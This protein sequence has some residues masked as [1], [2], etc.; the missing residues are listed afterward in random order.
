[1]S[2]EDEN[3]T[4]NDCLWA[5]L[6]YWKEWRVDFPMQNFDCPDIIYGQVG[7][8]I[9]PALQQK[10]TTCPVLRVSRLN[11]SRRCQAPGYLW[12]LFKKSLVTVTWGLCSVILRSRQSRSE[13]LSLWLGF[14]VGSPR[15]REKG[16]TRHLSRRG[17]EEANSTLIS[18]RLHP[19][20]PI[21]SNAA[22]GMLG[23][24]RVLAGI[25]WTNRKQQTFLANTLFCATTIVYL[26]NF[27]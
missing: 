18:D 19:L 10:F 15:S 13:K 4:K 16:I 8:S 11:P 22:I 24:R 12:E 20:R 26:S 14:S 23:W 9:K 3:I 17:R 27:Y 21:S 5:S 25:R 2:T 7:K 6:R 1:M